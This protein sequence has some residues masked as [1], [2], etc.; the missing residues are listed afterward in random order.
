V[1]A[2]ENADLAGAALLAESQRREESALS[3]CE[4]AIAVQ[5]LSLMAWAQS[6]PWAHPQTG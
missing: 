3:D 5:V 2:V 6:R 1:S 4:V